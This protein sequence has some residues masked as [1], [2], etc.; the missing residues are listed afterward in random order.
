MFLS[1]TRAEQFN[2][3]LTKKAVSAALAATLGTAIGGAGTLAVEVA[4]RL[5]LEKALELALKHKDI[6]AAVIL[7]PV[8]FIFC[9]IFVTLAVFIPFL[10]DEKGFV[11]GAP[12][13][14]AAEIP[15]DLMQ[16]FLAAQKEYGVAW[17]V[18][19]A[20]AS[21]ESS[22]GM[23]MGPSSVGAVGFMQFMPTTWSG[24]NNPNARDSP[25]NPVWDT[26]PKRIAAFGGYGLDANGD[27]VA[28]PFNS[29]DAVFAAA[30][31]L[32]ANGFDSSVRQAL[33]MY[34]HSEAYVNEVLAKAA[35]Y[36]TEMIPNALAK[37]LPVPKAFFNI[38]SPFGYRQDPFEGDLRFH[39]GID[40]AAPEG[41]PV[42]S[43]DAGR[44]E[45]AG[46]DRG[47]GLCIVVDHGGYK[48]K[49]A[50][51]HEKL[52]VAGDVVEAGQVIGSVGSSGR[53]TGP[54]LHFGVYVNKTWCNPELIL[55]TN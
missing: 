17:N 25:T 42:F 27:G 48:T 37:A 41:T 10:P 4:K 34:N 7:L 18:L 1:Q 12:T 36:S 52:V 26:D 54:H 22:F 13:I 30:R 51:L 45:F 28:D 35:A 47:Y 6:L 46:W 50:H 39:E 16:I 29:W 53:S 43:A 44:V 15:P 40:I 32:K 55:K 14:Y 2:N 3:Q 21:I 20:L 23:N 24:S 5:A 31:F 49:Y 8:A 38:T 11:G 19:A 9:F 33:W